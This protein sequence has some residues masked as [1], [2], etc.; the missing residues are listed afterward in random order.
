MMRSTGMTQLEGAGRLC[1]WP[2]CWPRGAPGAAFGPGREPAAPA[3]PTTPA[4]PA[5]PRLLLPR[6]HRPRRRSRRARRSGDHAR[7]AAGHSSP[8][9]GAATPD[10]QPPDTSISQTIDL[11][12]HPASCSPARRPGTTA[13]RRITDSFAKLNDALGKN[14]LTAAG[15]PLAV[16]TETDDSG[17]KFTR[18]D[19]ARQGARRQDRLRAGHED[20][21][22]AGRQGDALPAPRRL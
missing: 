4:A 14:K 6:P 15:H 7:R 3:A 2:R 8:D 19:P 13:S 9:T 21:R 16:F 17:F 12:T 20:R 5:A 10:K 18:H 1:C 11:P 22:D